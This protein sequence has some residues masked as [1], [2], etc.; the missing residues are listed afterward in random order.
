LDFVRVVADPGYELL[1]NSR[2]FGVAALRHLLQHRQRGLAKRNQRVAGAV[3]EQRVAIRDTQSQRLHKGV[4][5]PRAVDQ[6]PIG[7][8]RGGDGRGRRQQRNGQSRRR[9]P[10]SAPVTS[11][12]F[13][14]S[15]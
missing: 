12:R 9:P 3:P 14:L 2:R 4:V 10:R 1:G 15:G 13:V 11:H 7:P 5:L 8:G 6:G